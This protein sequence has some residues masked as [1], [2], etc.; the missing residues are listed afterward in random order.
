MILCFL[1]KMKLFAIQ[2]IDVLKFSSM[3]TRGLRYRNEI[4]NLFWKT[5]FVLDKKGRWIL[6]YKEHRGDKD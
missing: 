5:N 4:G 6:L 3:R 1:S 2:Y